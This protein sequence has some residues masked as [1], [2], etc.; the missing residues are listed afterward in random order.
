MND[1]TAARRGAGLPAAAPIVGRRR[2]LSSGDVDVF[3]GTNSVD[4][5]PYLGGGG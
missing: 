4:P 2:F 1:A 3:R 5:T